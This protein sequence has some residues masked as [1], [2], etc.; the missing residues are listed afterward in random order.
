MLEEAYGLCMREIVDHETENVDD[1]MEPFIG[2][3][4]ICETDLVEQN[5]LH[6]EN[7]DRLRQLG[8]VL[9]DPQTERNDLCREEKVDDLSI[10]GLVDRL[11]PRGLDE[12]TDNSQGRQP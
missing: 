6:D 5:F 9:H 4:Y 2:V 8:A 3:T 12:G 1:G 7:R 10:I 11:T